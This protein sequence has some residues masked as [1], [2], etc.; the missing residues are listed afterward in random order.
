MGLLVECPSRRTTNVRESLLFWELH[1]ATAWTKWEHFKRMR[2]HVLSAEKIVTRLK[3][4]LKECQWNSNPHRIIVPHWKSNNKAFVG[5][6]M[7]WRLIHLIL[8]SKRQ[9]E[10]FQISLFWGAIPSFGQLISR[11]FLKHLP[12]VRKDFAMC[13]VN[14]ILYLTHNFLQS[15]SFKLS[16]LDSPALILWQCS[17]TLTLFLLY[18]MID[19]L[20]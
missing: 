7:R 2:K 17:I 19:V 10:T 6:L 8:K 20:I 3:I 18:Q 16:K 12:L 9:L 11:Q 1:H 13:S 5:K 4:S 15:S 14:L